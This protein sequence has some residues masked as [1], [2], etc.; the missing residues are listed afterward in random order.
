[1]EL[2][3]DHQSVKIL[4]PWMRDDVGFTPDVLF[5]KITEMLKQLDGQEL[6]LVR[7]LTALKGLK[8]CPLLSDLTTVTRVQFQAQLYSLTSQGGPHYPSRRVQRCAFG[9]LDA[10]YPAG[11]RTRKVIS[12]MFK[13]FHPLDWPRTT[14]G[15]IQRV[16]KRFLA[17]VLF[18]FSWIRFFTK[19][20]F[21]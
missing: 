3:F 6:G 12:Q 11:A 15:L 4:G 21:G 5:V 19:P 16:W 13:I 9:A 2:P 7:T 20:F 10:L 14:A 17:F 8:N 18:I 1:M